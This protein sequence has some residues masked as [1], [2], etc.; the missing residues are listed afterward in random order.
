MKLRYETGTAT[1][2]HFIVIMLLAFVGGIASIASQCHNSGF[3][4]CA[5]GSISTFIYVLLLACWFGFLAMLG[6]AAQDQRSHRLAR[7]LIIAELMVAFIALFNARHFPNLL[8]L[9]TSIV[10]AGFAAWIIMLAYR[11]SRSKGG[12]ILA[13]TP[14]R[15]RRRPPTPSK[16]TEAS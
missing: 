6:Y 1:L 15:P 3:A 7:V 12:R 16:K 4:D 14:A 9:I 8:G 2:T 5:Q 11:L 10:D 13:K